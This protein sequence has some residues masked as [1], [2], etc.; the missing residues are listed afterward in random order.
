MRPCAGMPPWHS[1]RLTT[2]LC[3]T[4][5]KR[6]GYLYRRYPTEPAGGYPALDRRSTWAGRRPDRRGLV[7]VPSEP[8]PVAAARFTSGMPAAHYW[9]AR[10]CLDRRGREYMDQVQYFCTPQFRGQVT[11]MWG[12]VRNGLQDAVIEGNTGT[13]TG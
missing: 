4:A 8:P 9:M 5:D 7:L 13:G 6:F 10:P 3:L 12:Q 1:G 2:T 11:D